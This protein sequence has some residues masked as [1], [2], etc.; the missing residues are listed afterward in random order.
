[1]K[2]MFLNIIDYFVKQMLKLVDFNIMC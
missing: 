2:Q 1:V